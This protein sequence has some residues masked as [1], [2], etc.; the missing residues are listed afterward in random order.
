M[1]DEESPVLPKE[2]K[3]LLCQYKLKVTFSPVFSRVLY[4]LCG[5]S[6]VLLIRH[7]FVV[8]PKAWLQALHGAKRSSSPAGEGFR[9]LCA[10]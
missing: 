2:R 1:V 8:P 9:V 3:E 4:P 5:L 6:R 10:K 7:S